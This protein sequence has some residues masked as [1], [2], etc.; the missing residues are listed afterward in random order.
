MR[1]PKHLQKGPQGGEFQTS[2]D[3]D[4]LPADMA[5]LP[6]D[7]LYPVSGLSWKSIFQAPAESILLNATWNSEGPILLSLARIPH[8]RAK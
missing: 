2:V 7:N 5:E 4:E 6:A 8:S 1:M 3:T